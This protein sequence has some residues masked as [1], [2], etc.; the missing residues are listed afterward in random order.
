MRLRT[1]D[2]KPPKT[3]KKTTPPRIPCVSPDVRSSGAVGGENGIDAPLS[4]L[5]FCWKLGWVKVDSESSVASY[6][7]IACYSSRAD[8]H[9]TTFTRANRKHIR[10]PEAFTA[11]VRFLLANA[12]CRGKTRQPCSAVAGVDTLPVSH[13]C[14]TFSDDTAL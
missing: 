7:Y 9:I 14:S 3:T 5:K 11:K 1:R 8:G 6:L 10:A 12:R 13:T 2:C 4:R